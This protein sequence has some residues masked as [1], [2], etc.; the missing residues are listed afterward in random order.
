MDIDIQVCGRPVPVSVIAPDPATDRHCAVLYYHGGGFLCGEMG[1][2]PRLYQ[3][4]F[5]QAGY[6]LVTVEYP[7]CPEYTLAG[8]VAYSLEALGELVR[9]GLPQLGCTSYVLFGRS[10]GAYLVLKLAASLR[11]GTPELLQP[12]AIL[13]FY[14][15]WN[16][17]EA[18]LNEPV[19]HYQAMP[20]VDEQTV[21]TICGEEGELVLGGGNAQR[22]SVYL[23]ARQTGRW[24]ELLGVRN[25]AAREALSLSAEDVA[26]LP[27][28]FITASTGDQDVPLK[29]SK[30]LMR[31]AKDSVM[32]QVYYLEHDFDRDI[33]NP[34]GREAYEAALAFLS[35]HLGC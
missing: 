18:F 26:A 8:S 32:H 16:L 22:F 7:L 34:A 12:A 24:G 10:A 14:G 30:T 29:Q 13:D 11:C 35:N 25:D 6:T 31:A 21:A 23:Y 3:R 27:P 17:D 4:M 9:E 33:T 1:D 15:F 28:L 5:T 19:A 2:L 20:H